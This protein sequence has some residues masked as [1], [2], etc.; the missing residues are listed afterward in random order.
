MIKKYVFIL[1][2]IFSSQAFS[3][4][5]EDMEEAIIGGDSKT[6]MSLIHRGVEVNSVNQQGNSLLMQAVRRDMPEFFS[7]LLSK[8]VRVDTRNANNETALALAAFLG[9]FNYV[10]AL[11]DKGA[12]INSFGWSPLIYASFN[13]HDT[14]AAYLIEHGAEVNALAEN[15]SSALFFAARFGHEKVVDLL[16]A[17]GAFASIVNENG[18]TAVDWA[19]ASKNTEIAD[20]LKQA[21][22]AESVA[23]RFEL[24]N[25]AEEKAEEKIVVEKPKTE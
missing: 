16:L 21:G 18:K 9:R 1:C 15:G 17:E 7:F 14:I 22:G 11:V 2:F 19:L 24:V 25:E 20:K 13:G 4:V 5:L 3:G 10:K 23:L 8:K 6:A 12:E